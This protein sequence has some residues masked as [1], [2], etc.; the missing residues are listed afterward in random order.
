MGKLNLLPHKSWNVYSEKNRARVQRDEAKAEA[1]AA[2]KQQRAQQAEQESRLSILRSR[3]RS[4]QASSDT[5]EPPSQSEPSWK[6]A[7]T[8][9][10]S[11]A[12]FLEE[13]T[14]AA[15]EKFEKDTTV[16]L[17]ETLDGKKDSPWYTQSD[18]GRSKRET[19]LRPEVR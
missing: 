16:Y 2:D 9:R 6:T 14:K 4:N 17:G 7:A 13:K 3:A 19:Q 5:A 1:E 12:A 18:L 10:T 11:H 8:A 15:K